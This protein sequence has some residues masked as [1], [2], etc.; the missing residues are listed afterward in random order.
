MESDYPWV[1]GDRILEKEIE[2]YVHRT[3]DEYVS[4]D[5]LGYKDLANVLEDSVGRQGY[6]IEQVLDAFMTSEYV[7]ENNSGYKIKGDEVDIPFDNVSI[8]D[9]LIEEIQLRKTVEGAMVGLVKKA[10]TYYSSKLDESTTVLGNDDF[11]EKSWNYFAESVTTEQ[12]DQVRSML[13][14]VVFAADYQPLAEARNNSPAFQEFQ[15]K[16]HEIIRDTFESD[17]FPLFRGI[18]PKYV[19][20]RSPAFEY[21]EPS[22]DSPEYFVTFDEQQLQEVLDHVRNDTTVME[23]DRVDSWT[24]NPSQALK[25]ATNSGEDVGFVLR[26]NTPLGEIAHSTLVFEDDLSEQEFTVFGDEREFEPDQFN[27]RE[28]MTEGKLSEEDWVWLYKNLP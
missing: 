9:T 12:E 20:S 6:P 10:G 1:K 22:S 17:T 16:Q 15:N 5:P 4:E 11:A 3:L 8:S 24:T 7:M 19:A 18:G 23:R 25:F 21:S 28:G 2:N 14:D 27:A 26:R 13:K